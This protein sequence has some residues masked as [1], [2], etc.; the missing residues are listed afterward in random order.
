MLRLTLILKDCLPCL[1]FDILRPLHFAVGDGSKEEGFDSKVVELLAAS[2]A[3]G[4][5]D[6]NRMLVRFVPF[7]TLLVRLP[8]SFF[9]CI[10]NSNLNNL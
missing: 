4:I 6:R 3:A 9:I 7:I 5:R 1:I 10:C 2:G 8:V